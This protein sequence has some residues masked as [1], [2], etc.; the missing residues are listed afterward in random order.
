MFLCFMHAYLNVSFI[1]EMLIHGFKLVE[2]SS[3]IYLIFG[4]F[5]CCKQ[6]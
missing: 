2:N 6:S 4:H 3:H 1:W 5:A